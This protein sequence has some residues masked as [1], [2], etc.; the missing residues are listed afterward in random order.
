M[1]A[2]SREGEFVKAWSDLPNPQPQP[3]LKAFMETRTSTPSSPGYMKAGSLGRWC[4][5]GRSKQSQTPKP[6]G[7]VAV[8]LRSLGR[9]AAWPYQARP[10]WKALVEL[11]SVPRS[12]PTAS[13]WHKGL[14]SR[15]ARDGQDDRERLRTEQRACTDING[16]V[17]VMQASQ[18][19]DK[20]C[21]MVVV[22]GSTTGRHRGFSWGK[23]Y[24]E[25]A[26]SPV[27]SS[28]KG[29]TAYSDSPAGPG[30]T[31]TTWLPAVDGL[32]FTCFTSLRIMPDLKTSLAAGGSHLVLYWPVRPKGKFPSRA[33]LPK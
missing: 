33:F 20:V 26:G 22:P 5:W 28:W 7:P 17:S 3:S 23:P 16:K 21:V 30:G 27:S 12:P 11:C 19:S 1:S 24:G 14:V 6:L 2:F 32:D 10:R 8:L 31:Q 18:L 15:C 9:R 13:H 4:T 25:E 29:M